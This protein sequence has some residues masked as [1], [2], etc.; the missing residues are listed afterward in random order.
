MRVDP[1]VRFEQTLAGNGAFRNTLTLLQR[2]CSGG[3][4]CPLHRRFAP[5]TGSLK[6]SLLTACLFQRISNVMKF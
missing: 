1:L 4:R 2:L 3:I 5:N 6:M